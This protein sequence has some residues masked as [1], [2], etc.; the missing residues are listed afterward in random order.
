MAEAVGT[1]T[2]G[3]WQL[4]DEVLV[5][6]TWLIKSF[7]SPCLAGSK[8]SAADGDPLSP[9]DITTYRQIVG[10]LQYCTLTC[11]DIAFSVNQLCQHMHNPSTLYWTTA[12][13][14]QRTRS[15]TM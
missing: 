8:M 10:A 13:R 4:L 9:T 5:E 14:V 2:L 6:C 15:D 11:L 7:S 3:F 1:D 12:K